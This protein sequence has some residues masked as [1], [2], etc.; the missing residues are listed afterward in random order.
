LEEE[1]Q[2]PRD[3]LEKFVNLFH[4]ESFNELPPHQKWD[5]AIVLKEGHKEVT[6]KIYPL[7]YKE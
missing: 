1:I 4:E 7:S 5:H 3:Y 2:E 6:S